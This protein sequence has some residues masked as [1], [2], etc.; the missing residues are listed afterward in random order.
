LRC[1]EGFAA[2]VQKA[3]MSESK[4]L[5]QLQREYLK[6]QKMHQSLLASQKQHSTPHQLN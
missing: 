1:L 2:K 4:N 6:L 3:G 5:E